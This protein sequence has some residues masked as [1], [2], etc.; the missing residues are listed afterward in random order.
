[1][2]TYYTVWATGADNLSVSATTT[3]ENT[4]EIDVRSPDHRVGHV[5]I[6]DLPNA[7][8]IADAIT[9]AVIGPPENPYAAHMAHAEAMIADNKAKEEAMKSDWV[10]KRD[11]PESVRDWV[12]QNSSFNA[13]AKSL[14]NRL[15]TYGNLSKK[16]IAA[17]QERNL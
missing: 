8:E 12:Y 7:K 6:H 15:D 4:L 11:V 3:S 17:V 5:T 10:A 13:F 14:R 9:K 16:Q 2:S 1:M